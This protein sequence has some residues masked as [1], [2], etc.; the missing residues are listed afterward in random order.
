MYLAH[1]K[2]EGDLI[3]IGNKVGTSLNLIN[4][5]QVGPGKDYSEDELTLTG[6]SII[7]DSGESRGFTVILLSEDEGETPIGFIV[8]NSD[9][10]KYVSYFE[11]I[12]GSEMRI[13][14]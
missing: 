11:D 12:L 2:G 10:K 8:H 13:S 5:G 7:F 4:V 3:L 9:A 1:F 6:E 14:A